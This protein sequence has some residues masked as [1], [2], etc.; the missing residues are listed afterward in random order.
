MAKATIKKVKRQRTEQVSA[1]CVTEAH[2][3]DPS[4]KN[5]K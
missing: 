2:L 4:E 5:P 3:P 1:A